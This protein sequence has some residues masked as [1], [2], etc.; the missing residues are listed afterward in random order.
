MSYS[1]KLKNIPPIL[2]MELKDKH[3]YQDIK[4]SASLIH[5]IATN[6]SN[7]VLMCLS[8]DKI[9][10]DETSFTLCFPFDEVDYL[11]FNSDDFFVLQRTNVLYLTN[12]GEYDNLNNELE[13]LFQFALANELTPILPYRIIYKKTNTNL[14]K[15]K[16]KTYTIELQLPIE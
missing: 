3:T 16:K 5:S 8:E 7:S 4:D 11:G 1:I 13:A 10:T 6:N 2:S 15:H 12:D 14:F 9:L